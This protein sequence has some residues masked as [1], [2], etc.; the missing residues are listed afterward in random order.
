MHV[1]NDN[2]A[3]NSRIIRTKK[4]VLQTQQAMA[5]KAFVIAAQRKDIAMTKLTPSK[6]TIH[7]ITILKIVS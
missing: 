1:V 7:D 6:K 5:G 2:D 4:A 3:R